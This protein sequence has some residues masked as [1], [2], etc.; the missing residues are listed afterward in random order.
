MRQVLGLARAIERSIAMV[1][2]HAQ[3]SCSGSSDFK[4]GDA[5]IDKTGDAPIDMSHLARYTLG[6]AVLEREVLNLFC[7]QSLS[8]LEQ[9][10]AA[11][12]RA[13]IREAAHSLNGSARAVGAWR[14]ARAAECIE[15]LS[16]NAPPEE[17]TA[18]IAELEASLQEAMTFIA[19][20][21]GPDRV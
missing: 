6:D 10:R 16:E 9:L 5:P 2:E 12:T 11:A 3:G 17:R 4:T 1:G 19:K 21:A 15:N 8:Y 14:M 20:M 13:A 18:Q 7:T